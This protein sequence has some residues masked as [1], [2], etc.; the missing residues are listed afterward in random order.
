MSVLKIK[1]V[2]EN[3]KLP[4]RATEGSAG[5][6]LYACIEEPVVPT[7]LSIELEDRNQVALI[8]ARSSMGIKYS[9]TPANAVGVVDSDYRGEVCVFLHNY[10]DVE[11]TVQPQDR[12]AQMVIMPVLLP[13]IEEVTELSD[14]E[15]GEG[16]FGS[17]GK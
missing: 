7:G 16:G 8:F 17:T 12:V 5:M 6:D 14:T 4:F 3:A 13:E 1:R 2:R 15:R 10:S 9:V 11:Y